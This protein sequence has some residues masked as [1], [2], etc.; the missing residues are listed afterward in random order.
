VTGQMDDDL[1]EGR[2]LEADSV[3]TLS[4]RQG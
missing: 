1:F 4:D 2:E 3:V